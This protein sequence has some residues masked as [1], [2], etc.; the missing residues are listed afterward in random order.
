MSR[1]GTPKLTI[2]YPDDVGPDT[3]FFE[4]THLHVEGAQSP[5]SVIAGLVTAVAIS[6]ESGY[7]PDNHQQ[8]VDIVKNMLDEAFGGSD[9]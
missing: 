9:D 5:A 8:M 4:V 1:H 7:A 6:I 3:D 2:H